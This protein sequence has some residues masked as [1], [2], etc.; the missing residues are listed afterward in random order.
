MGS[1]LDTGKYDC[2]QYLV[3]K[4]TSNSSLTKDVCIFPYVSICVGVQQKSKQ[5]YDK[6]K[7]LASMELEHLPWQLGMFINFCVYSVLKETWKS[8][9]MTAN[10]RFD[11]IYKLSLQNQ[12]N[13][14]YCLKLLTTL[15]AGRLCLWLI[16]WWQYIP[17]CK[18]KE[19][20][21]YSN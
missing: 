4:L 14:S 15:I 13:Y 8:Y 9:K 18:K 17:P 12:I 11:F 21:I 5:L 2:N 19:V 6:E 7:Q 10:C 16:Q 3:K 20:L 1:W